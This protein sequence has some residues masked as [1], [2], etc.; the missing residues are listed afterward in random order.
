MP[1]MAGG[2]F[3]VLRRGKRQQ[4]ARRIGHQNLQMRHGRSL[5]VQL[6]AAGE[7]PF[8]IDAHQHES[9]DCE[10]RERRS[11]MF[12]RSL[13]FHSSRYRRSPSQAPHTHAAAL[14]V[15]FMLSKRGQ[16]IAQGQDRWPAH[17]MVSKGG[18]DDVGERKIVVPNPDKWGP[19]FDELVNLIRTLLMR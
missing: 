16:E 4:L 17:K 19:R 10:I 8:Q 11:T 9:F 5:L 18:P 2:G 6:V 13:S 7:F 15:D 12:F 3:G 14:L 1:M